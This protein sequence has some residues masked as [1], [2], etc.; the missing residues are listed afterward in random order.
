MLYSR[1]L[2]FIHPVHKRLPPL[3]LIAL[4]LPF[5]RTHSHPSPSITWAKSIKLTHSIYLA[6]S[7]N[8]ETQSPDIL[9]PHRATLGWKQVNV[10][11][12]A[13]I[14]WHY[15]AAGG[16][17]SRSKKK[18]PRNTRVR[19]CAEPMPAPSSQLK[20]LTPP[21]WILHH[22]IIKNPSFYPLVTPVSEAIWKGSPLCEENWEIFPKPQRNNLKC[23]NENYGDVSFFKIWLNLGNAAELHSILSRL[24]TY[25]ENKMIIL[26]PV[27]WSILTPCHPQDAKNSTDLISPNPHS[28]DD[29]IIIFKMK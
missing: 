2:E 18:K 22:K 14:I 27:Y 13:V 23:H 29:F 12:D 9:N 17:L 1:T 28:R 26:A 7:I 24:K 16:T 25:S 15:F 21:R 6:I 5:S 20:L 4:C 10:T 19:G 8:H 11:D 3:F